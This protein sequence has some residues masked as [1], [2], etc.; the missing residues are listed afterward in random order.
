MINNI[1]NRTLCRPIQSVMIILMIK[2]IR[3]LL[4]GRLILLNPLYDYRPNWTPLSPNILALHVNIMVSKE[5]P[6]IKEQVTVSMIIHHRLSNLILDK[7][8][9]CMLIS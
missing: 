8:N 4:R 5:C 7:I 9:I 1:G 3:L 2:Q 6:I